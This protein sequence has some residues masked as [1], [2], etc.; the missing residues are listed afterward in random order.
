[1]SKVKKKKCYVCRTIGNIVPAGEFMAAGEK[2]LMYHPECYYRIIE[3]IR[4][5]MKHSMKKTLAAW[6]KDETS[7]NSEK[8]D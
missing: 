7:K 5:N 8:T 4:E 1:M 3:V 2:I 6:K